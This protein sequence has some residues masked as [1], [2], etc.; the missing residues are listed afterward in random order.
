M[1]HSSPS[2]YPGTLNVYATP[3]PYLA[4]RYSSRSSPSGGVLGSRRKGSHSTRHCT[5]ESLMACSR[6]RFPTKHQGHTMSEIILTTTGFFDIVSLSCFGMRYTLLRVERE[7][8]QLFLETRLH[9]F[10]MG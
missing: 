5:P 7:L 1:Q 3:W 8:T 2:S 4:T 9:F 6:L 10:S